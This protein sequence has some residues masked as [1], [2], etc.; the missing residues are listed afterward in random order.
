VITVGCNCLFLEIKY[1]DD[2]DDDDEVTRR[3][4]LAHNGSNYAESRKGV[5]FGGPNDGRPHL[6]VKFPKNPQKGRGLVI[7]SQVGE[8]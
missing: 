2:D 8:K 5:P 7:P 6:G 1:A 3:P 4:I